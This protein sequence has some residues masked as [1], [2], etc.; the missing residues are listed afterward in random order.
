[1]QCRPAAQRSSASIA[2]RTTGPPPAYPPIH[3]AMHGSRASCRRP[4][5]AACREHGSH[6]C[7]PRRRARTAGRVRLQRIEM[8]TR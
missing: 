8:S 7:L 4:A 5:A 6:R 1:V 2:A 3:G